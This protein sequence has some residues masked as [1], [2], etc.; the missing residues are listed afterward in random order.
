MALEP[1]AITSTPKTVLVEFK[2]YAGLKNIPIKAVW[3]KQDLQFQLHEGFVN[4]KSIESISWAI[5]V[6]GTGDCLNVGS[7]NGV[8]PANNE[9]LFDLLV[10][11]LES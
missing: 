3:S 8:T 4:A 6:G 2:G 10:A 1:I 5:A 11:A 7:V 9:E